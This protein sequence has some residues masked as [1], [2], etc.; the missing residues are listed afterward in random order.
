MSLALTSRR[1]RALNALLAVNGTHS[2]SSAGSWSMVAVVMVG[3][4]VDGTCQSG[5]PKATP[6][7]GIRRLSSIVH[8]L[9]SIDYSP[10][11]HRSLILPTIDRND[12]AVCSLQILSRRASCF[13]S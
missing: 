7:G 4:L 10:V 12:A 8:R 5:R 1:G 2:A 11:R 9:A 13:L 6:H 3:I